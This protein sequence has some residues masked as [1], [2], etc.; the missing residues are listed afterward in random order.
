VNLAEWTRVQG[1]RPQTAYRWFREGTLPVPAV[2]VNQ[3]TVLVSPGAPAGP[4]AWSYGLYARVS[5]YGYK[6]D[7]GRQVARLTSWAAGAGGLVVRVEAGAGSGVNGSRAR[8]AAYW[9]TRT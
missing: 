8:S 9:Q 6:A 1:I 7:L 3:R 5:S 4:A 2:R